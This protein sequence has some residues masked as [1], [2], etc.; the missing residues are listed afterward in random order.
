M[1]DEII[2][3]DFTDHD[4]S[5]PWV[6][7]GAEGVKALVNAYLSSRTSISALNVPSVSQIVVW[8][9]ILAPNGIELHPILSFSGSGGSGGAT[10]TATSSAAAN[11]PQATPTTTTSSYSVPACCVAGANTCNCANF[12]TR[13]WAQWFHDTYD[14]RDVNRLDSDHDGVVCESLPG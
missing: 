3:P 8:W 14:P 10:P 6:S 11:T 5:S 9:R 12:T 13:S 1:I 7:D 2:A 4:P